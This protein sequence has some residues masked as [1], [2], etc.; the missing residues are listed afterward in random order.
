MKKPAGGIESQIRGVLEEQSLL[1]HPFYRKWTEGTLERERFQEYARQ[2][3]HFEANFPRFLSAIHTR[4]E[5]PEL[6]QL[7]LDNLWDEEHGERNHAALWLDFARAVG[8]SGD[9]VAAAELR[10]PTQALIEHFRRTSQEARLAEALATLFA[11]EGQVPAVARAKIQGLQEH[12]GFEPDQ[13][14]F[15][16]VHLVADVAHADAEIRAI[17]RL[18][19][20]AGGEDEIVKAVEEACRLLYGFLDGCYAA[21]AR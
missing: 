12:Y 8:V 13:Y 16:S 4:T 6:R 17:E 11:Y 20:D 15:F 1:K 3:Y 18:S 9:E 19:G 21:V 10:P 5:S 7:I 14:E 2:Y